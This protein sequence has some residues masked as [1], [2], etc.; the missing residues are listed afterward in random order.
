M[1]FAG[2]RLAVS[3]PAAYETFRND[4]EAQIKKEILPLLKLQEADVVDLRLSRW[5]HP[6]PVPAPGL[7]ADGVIDAIRAPF[8]NRVFFVQQDNWMLAAL[9]TCIMEALS[10]APHAEM[11]ALS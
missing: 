10:W 5:G 11:A 7:I 3:T 9:E 1:P 8:K 2:S 6:M 4:F